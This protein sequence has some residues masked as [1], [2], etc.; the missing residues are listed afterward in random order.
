MQL[1]RDLILIARARQAAQSG[2]AAAIRR[3][4]G[5]S[6]AEVATAI[7]V[8]PSAV[9]KWESGDRL[10]RSDVARRYAQLLEALDRETGR[11]REPEAVPA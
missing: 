7:G 9:C 6:L 3:A 4:A 8:T 2:E 1:T 5:L 11:R 10:P